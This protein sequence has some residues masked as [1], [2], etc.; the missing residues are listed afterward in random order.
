MPSRVLKLFVCVEDLGVTAGHLFL[1]SILTSF[2]KEVR[3]ILNIADPK[4]SSIIPK[5]RAKY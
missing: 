1:G 4:Q 3:E 2:L 5:V